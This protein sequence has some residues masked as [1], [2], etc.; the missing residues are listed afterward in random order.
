MLAL[1]VPKKAILICIACVCFLAACRQEPPQPYGGE[2]AV[3]LFEPGPPGMAD[4][5]LWA[6]NENTLAV[7]LV[8]YEFFSKLYVYD[9][10]SQQA[11]LLFDTSENGGVLWWKTWSPD[12]KKLVFSS[13][14]DTY[15]GG[16]W[17]VDL[18][19]PSSPQHLLDRKEADWSRGGQ[20]AVTRTDLPNRRTYIS[21][22]E[23]IDGE[24]IPIYLQ[25][26]YIHKLSWSPDGKKL[27]LSI[28]Y[29]NDDFLEDIYVLDVDTLE[30]TQLTFDGNNH[31]PSWSS[32]GNLIAYTKYEGS[33]HDQGMSSFRL[34]ITN[35]DGS[36]DIEVPGVTG[37]WSPTWSPD[38]ER[39][40]YVS[41]GAVFLVDLIDVFGTDIYEIEDW[42]CP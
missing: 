18:E 26:G 33:D 11:T 13:H 19:D 15:A 42:P 5:V 2:N 25:K 1:K 14:S 35:P 31:D 28:D 37:G 24:E 6:P 21:I 7:T 3:L 4:E 10:R 8:G 36:C 9:I 12:G 38:G 29:P 22:F 39:I 16:L 40:A 23:S 32:R 20:L 17:I 34:H 41:E 27:V 30:M